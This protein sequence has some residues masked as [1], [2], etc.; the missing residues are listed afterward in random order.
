MPKTFPPAIRVSLT[1][2]IIMSEPEVQKADG[3]SAF[4]SIV[5]VVLVAFL[6]IGLYNLLQPNEPDSPTS[7]IDE[8]RVEKV[9]EYEAEN[10]DYL[11]KIDS[12]HSERNSSLQGVMEKVSEGYRSIPQ[13]GN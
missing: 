13:P 7:A 3:C 8:G 5:T 10:A 6:I 12:Y 1:R 9:K 2:F 11:D 4:F